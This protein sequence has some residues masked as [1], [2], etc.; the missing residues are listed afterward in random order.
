[1]TQALDRRGSFNA[2]H[3]DSAFKV[4]F[5]IPK[6]EDFARQQVERR[7]LRR[8][9][10]DVEMLIY[11]ATAE[12]TILAKLRWY[13]SGGKVSSTQW[14]DVV[15]IIGGYSGT[16]DLDYLHEWADKLGLTELLN[17]AFAE[18]TTDDGRGMSD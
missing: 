14:S 18:A 11:V 4:D 8:I 1:V 2:I 6:K 5:F 10:P 9:S 12:D 15:G 13:L 3:L 17:Q 16:L 7:E